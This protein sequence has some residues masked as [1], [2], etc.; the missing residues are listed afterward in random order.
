MN[1]KIISAGAGSGKTYSLTQQMASLLKPKADGSAEVRASGILATTFTNKAA[2]ELK[3]RVRVKLLE[4]GL[5]KEADELGRAM[6]GTVHAI[7]VQLLKR[8]AFEAGVSP[9]VDIIADEDHKAIFN[10]SIATILTKE[11]TE[12]ME[13]LSDVLGFKKNA[14]NSKDWRN[15]LKTITEYARTNNLGPV[16]LE[17]S[18]Q[19]SIKSYFELLPEVSKHSAEYFKT[20]LE[21]LLETTV[22]ELRQHPDATKKKDTLIGTLVNQRKSLKLKGDLYWYEWLQ[23]A[24]ACEDAPAK[25]RETVAELLEL[26]LL[27][28]SHPD[29]HADLRN[30]LDKIFELAIEALGEYESYKKSRGLIDY[31]DMEVMILKL[32]E[33]P[34]VNELLREELDL[35]L[36]DEFQDTNPIQLKI[37]LQLT[38]IAKQSIWVGDPKQSI[39]GFRG[40]DPELMEAIINS[41]PKDNIQILDKS[42][43]SRQDL[44]NMVNGLFCTAFRKMPEERIALK[45]PEQL[46]KSNEPE[47]LQHAVQQWVFSCTDDKPAGEWIAKAIAKATAELL[48]QGL[49][50]RGKGDSET[51]M[52]LAGDIAILCRSNYSC[53]TIAAELHNQGLKASISRAGLMQTPEAALLLACLKFILNEQDSVSIAEIMLLMQQ[54]PL[55]DIIENR[56][57]FLETHSDKSRYELWGEAEPIIGRL[58][59]MRRQTQE[60]SASEIMNLLVEQ[61]NIRHYAAAWGNAQQRFDNID[62]LRSLALQYEENCKRLHNAATLGG[63]LLWLEELARNEKDEQGSGSDINSVNVLTYHRSKGLEWPLV[64]CYELSNNLKE[65]LFDARIVSENEGVNLED[66]LAGRLICYWINPYGDLEKHALATAIEN[67]PDRKKI[68]QDALDEEVR[69]LYVGFTRARDYL[70]LPIIPQHRGKNQGTDWLNRV[71]HHGKAE[72]PAVDVMSDVC[73]W[74]W[75]AEEIPLKTTIFEYPKQIENCSAPEESFH[76]LSPYS[77]EQFHPTA[78]LDS[79][80]AWF[81]DEPEP[82]LESPYYYRNPLLVPE[83]MGVDNEALAGMLHLFIRAD[84]L[85]YEHA[86]RERTAAHALRQFRFDNFMDSATLLKFSE[87]FHKTL[88]QRYAP[89]EIES[90]VLFSH[91]K[92]EQYFKGSLDYL[93]SRND[94]KVLITD[95]LLPYEEFRKKLKKKLP[96]IA[97]NLR[98]ACLSMKETSEKDSNFEFLLHF[99]LEGILVGIKL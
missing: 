36:V 50:I 40:A 60:M 7:G 67:H 57:E 69:L 41:V 68:K 78:L 35:L 19:F 75:K 63:F 82:I 39:Y 3:E 72:L 87:N 32:L 86:L 53:Q 34:F 58:A 59:E 96:E 85:S 49:M 29:F 66:P 64:I 21:Y 54:L 71:F 11:K 10:Q 4:D 5:T 43:R 16:L 93:L 84:R 27:H 26:A 90:G 65:K 48:E 8:F 73:L 6:I 47:G 25:C 89:Q 28:D 20:R 18:K 30:Y 1:L 97:A 9:A 83:D 13:R 14:Y 46:Q 45:M 81:T 33:N 15:E 94:K 44:V 52:L 12:E 38:R 37:F 79:A 80:L 88:Q 91:S 2:A 76:Y 56:L 61:F 42:W 92:A 62:A 17:R 70:V 31:T 77:G 98:T 24:K 23:I 95:L 74:P 51:R 99:P 55:E 22:N